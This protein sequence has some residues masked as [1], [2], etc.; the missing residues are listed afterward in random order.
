MEALWTLLWTGRNTRKCSYAFAG[1]ADT[2]GRHD[3]DE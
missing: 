1:I 2:Q 3:G